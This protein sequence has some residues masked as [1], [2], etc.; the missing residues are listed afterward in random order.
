MLGFWVCAVVLLLCIGVAA[1]PDCDPELDIPVIYEHSQ[2]GAMELSL[3]VRNNFYIVHFVPTQTE[4]YYFS[5][6]DKQLMPNFRI[7]PG[8]YCE[9]ASSLNG[10]NLFHDTDDTVMQSVFLL[11]GEWYTLQLASS[12][13]DVVVWKSKAPAIPTW[14]VAII[15]QLHTATVACWVMLVFGVMAHDHF[16]PRGEV[17]DSV[18]RWTAINYVLCLLVFA[19]TWVVPVYFSLSCVLC[20]TVLLEMLFT[21]TKFEF[22][23]QLYQTWGWVLEWLL[24][25][26]AL[27]SIWNLTVNPNSFGMLHACATENCLNL[28]WMM[29]RYQYVCVGAQFTLVPAYAKLRSLTD[30]VLCKEAEKELHQALLLA[31]DKV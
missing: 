14:V 15:I 31:G 19:T 6:S 9:S 2:F 26:N 13:A 25:L 3:P 27:L 28:M 12:A 30:K 8:R 21:D 18:H 29:E 1:V 7:F 17:E 22:G 24:A 10:E 5:T 11:E 16:A 4:T 23:K 20:L